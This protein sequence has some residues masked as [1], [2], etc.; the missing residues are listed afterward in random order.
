MG[1]GERVDLGDERE[2]RDGVYVVEGGCQG[3][4]DGLLADVGDACE[5]FGDGGLPG[6]RG[7]LWADNEACVLAV[8]RDFKEFPEGGVFGEEFLEEVGVG[9]P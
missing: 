2:G 8:G 4:T 9:R 7:T 1:R 5:V 6:Q 3:V